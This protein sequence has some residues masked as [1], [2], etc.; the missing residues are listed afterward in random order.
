MTDPVTNVAGTAPVV[1][2]AILVVLEESSHSYVVYSTLPSC[3]GTVFVHDL[4]DEARNSR[5]QIAMTAFVDALTN[6]IAGRPVFTV[7][8]QT[9]Y[10]DFLISYSKRLD[11]GIPTLSLQHWHIKNLVG[12]NNPDGFSFKLDVILL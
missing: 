4:L 8:H 2:A 7:D 5:D 11:A 9:T 10:A 6:L 3:P 12:F 1:L